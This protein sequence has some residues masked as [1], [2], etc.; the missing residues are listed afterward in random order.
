MTLRIVDNPFTPIPAD[1]SKMGLVVAAGGL[2]KSGKT[3]FALTFPA[4]I[5]A[6]NFDHGIRELRPKFADKEINEATIAFPSEYDVD[7]YE[8]CLQRFLQVY[9][10]A[11]ENT[12]PGTVL[13]DTNTQVWQMTQTVEIDRIRQKRIKEAALK[14]QQLDPELARIFPFDYSRANMMM[15]NTM[16]RS[17]Q[18]A[19]IHGTNTVFIHRYKE[20]YVQTEGGTQKSGKYEP[21]WFAETPSIAQITG[22]V[23]TQRDGDDVRSM[24]EVRSSRFDRNSAG[25]VVPA[26]YNNMRFLAGHPGVDLEF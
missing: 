9:L 4:P 13:V 19:A 22:R 18:A 7:A 16:R 24:F 11:M 17:L 15:G 8:E 6:I 26:S 5:N 25:L 10:Y 1:I 12:G 21:Q 3:H 2:E 23:F 20:Q 14:R